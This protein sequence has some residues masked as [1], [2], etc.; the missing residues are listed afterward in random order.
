MEG[1]AAK[2]CRLVQ[3]DVTKPETIKAAVDKIVGEN[4]RIDG[5]AVRK[6]ALDTPLEEVRAMY[7]VNYF[8]VVAVNDEVMPHMV[9]QRSGKILNLGSGLG[10]TGLP[11]MSHYSAVKHAVR[12]YTDMLRIELAP[13]GV[14][15]CFV[16]P[17]YI[18]T[19]IGDG[20]ELPKG[21]I[22]H[23]F[24]RLAN[25]LSKTVFIGTT[26]EAATPADVF[27]SRLAKAVLAPRIPRHYRDGHLAIVPWL[28]SMFVPLW[29]YEWGFALRYGITPNSM[30]GRPFSKDNK[31]K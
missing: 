28:A 10:Y 19:H 3:L 8:G 14:Q 23:A 7:D 15:V 27:A 22:Y 11:T 31:G 5:V 1:L 6:P 21:S 24:P 2:G 17:G 29:I 12:S 20:Y 16:A 26:F 25:E 30:V 13:F 4:G 9:E 18:R